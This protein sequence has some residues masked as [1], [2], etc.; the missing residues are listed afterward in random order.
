MPSL[1]MAF[2]I[3]ARDN[4]SPVFAKVGSEAAKAA[5]SV[6][7]A[8]AAM[9]KAANAE[10]DAAARFALLRRVL[11]MC[12]SRQGTS[13]QH[14]RRLWSSWRRLSACRCVLRV[15]AVRSAQDHERAL[16]KL[17]DETSRASRAGKAFGGAFAGGIKA[18]AG[19]A[20]GALAVV[21]GFA[22]VHDFVTS[23]IAEARESQQVGAK[24]TAI[25]KATGGAAKISAGQV[26]ALTTAISNKT[27]MDDEAI[28]AGSNLLLT[29]RNVRNE[30][31]KGSDVF[32]R[33][34]AAAVD[35]SKAG[36]GSITGASKQLGKALKDPVKGI[37]A[38]NRAGVTFTDQQKEQIKAL[39]K[40][41]DTLGAQKIIL[42]EVE[43]QV[44]ASPRPAPRPARS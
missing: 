13:R 21:K 19:L 2:D 32:D 8:A 41:G 39:V 24:T 3:A 27:G 20:V 1:A 28:Q 29:F 9:Q 33:A 17:G 14:L 11:M 25:I 22:D 5:K 31:G 7:Q 44:G 10:A 37:S 38:L 4:A 40:S 16:K 35:L 34:T 15:T 18:G 36:F 6:E 30:A 43:H 42:G 26:G 12:G 23:S